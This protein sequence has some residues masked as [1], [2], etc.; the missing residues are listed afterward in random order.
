M[1][2][3]WRVRPS[4]LERWLATEHT[5]PDTSETSIQDA[6]ARP[7]RIP[8]RADLDAAVD[9]SR[10]QLVR[11]LSFVAQLT[12]GVEALGWPA[13]VVVGGHAVEF[14]TAGSYPT[15]DIDLAGASEPVS[16]VLDTWSFERHGRH[17]FDERLGIVV[18][19]PGSALTLAAREHL[20]SV[21]VGG[22][23]AH[24]LGIEDLIVD[25]L[26][27]CVFWKDE[28]SC[29]WARVLLK[30]ALELDEAYL[31]ARVREEHLADAFVSLRQESGR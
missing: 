19:V 4:D 31:S 6:V 21:K 11:R 8:G 20:V 23:V 15:Q 14:Y 17:W 16:E 5:R 27:A 9:A 29:R 26:A 22:G 10:D 28:E 13:P 3:L 30:G 2:R 12:L 7:T 25:R 24:I 18:E 1:G